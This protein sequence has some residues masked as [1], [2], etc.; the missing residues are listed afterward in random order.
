MSRFDVVIPTLNRKDKL[1]LCKESIRKQTFQDFSLYVYEDINH[2]KAPRIWNR[3]LRCNPSR[4]IVFLCDD[5]ELDRECFQRLLEVE[6]LDEKLVGFKQRNLATSCKAAMG[7]VGTKFADRFINRQV[8]CPDYDNMNVDG[9]LIESAEHFGAFVFADKC[10]LVHH[11][12]VSD[13]KYFDET[14]NITREHAAEDMLTR[15][16]RKKRGYVWGKDFR[17]LNSR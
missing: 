4:S 12:P 17:R 11:H 13:T 7:F 9:E 8:W 3:H 5:I 16:E 14:H 15:H 1:A 10:T 6:D 2:E